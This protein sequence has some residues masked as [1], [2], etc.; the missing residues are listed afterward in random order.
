M[1]ID[2]INI[3]IALFAGIVSFL[4][5]CILPLIPSYLS[6]IGGTSYSIYND[7]EKGASKKILIIRTVFFIIGFSII[8]VSL[9]IIFSSAGFLLSGIQ[10]TVNI[11]AGTVIIILGLNYIFN[12]IKIFNLEKRFHIKTKSSGVASAGL[13]GMAFGAGWT[14]CIGPILASILF[15]AGSSGQVING[16][17]LLIIYSFGLGIPFL[18]ASIFFTF[19]L[20]QIEKIKP[21]LNKIRIISGIFLVLIGLLVFMGSLVKINILFYQVAFQFDEW[22]KEFPLLAKLLFGLIFLGFLVLAV[23]AYIKKVWKIK[24]GNKINFKLLFLPARLVF[25]SLLLIITV[26]V[27]VG[28]IDIPAIFTSWLYFQGI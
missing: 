11:V 4:S 10:K 22:S 12:F 5:P 13:F 19:F 16:T 14:P 6:F 7:D 28:L 25:I 3:F 18:I 24:N 26:L 9:G 27:F 2:S 20:K 21:H 23:I 8:F 17:I 1:N 15:M